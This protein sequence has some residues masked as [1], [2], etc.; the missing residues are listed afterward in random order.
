MIKISHVFIWNWIQKYRSGKHLKNK[1]IQVYII[2]EAALKAGSYDLV[3]LW[4][5]IEPI[6]KEILA[7]DI[8]KKRNI[9]IAKRFL[10]HVVYKYGLHSVSSDGGTWYPQACQF[11]KLEHH[12]HSS[13]EKSIIERT[14][15]NIQDRTESFD[16]YFPCRKNKCRLKYRKQWFQLFVD[17][18][19]QE[20]IS[21]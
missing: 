12:L 21:S 19:N 18:H 11:L 15:Q 14:M 3:W 2:D 13:F 1:K 10:S 17:K 4:L 7:M 8:S 6:D 5:V 16:D 9:S 20:I